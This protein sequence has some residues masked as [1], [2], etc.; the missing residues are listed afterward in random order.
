[1]YSSVQYTVQCAVYIGDFFLE[2]NPEIK[3]VLLCRKLKPEVATK[4]S[5]QY[6]GDRMYI[7]IIIIIICTNI[8]KSRVSLPEPIFLLFY[9]LGYFL[10]LHQRKLK[11]RCQQSGLTLQKISGK[12]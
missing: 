9:L 3:P 4:K 8:G 10:R 5:P 7:I 11:T 12:S 2:S 6:C 1:M